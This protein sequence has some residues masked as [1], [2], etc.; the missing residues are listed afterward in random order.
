LQSDNVNE[1]LA[2]QSLSNERLEEILSSR[3]QV[4][5]EHRKAA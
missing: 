3:T 4:V 2:P 5:Y 1:W